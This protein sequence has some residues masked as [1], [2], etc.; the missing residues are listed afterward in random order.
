MIANTATSTTHHRD[1]SPAANVIEL[2]PW[3]TLT[4]D[5]HGRQATFSITVW[6]AEP[7]L[8]SSGALRRSP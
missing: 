4:T 7:L 3:S 1:V 6:N 2:P 5:H 8:T